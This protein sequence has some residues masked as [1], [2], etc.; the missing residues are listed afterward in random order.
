MTKTQTQPWCEAHL[1]VKLVKTPHG[2]TTCGSWDGEKVQALWRMHVSKSKWP[3]P[4][5]YWL[6]LF[7]LLLIWLFFASSH[8]RCFICPSCRKFDFETSFDDYHYC[9]RWLFVI[10]DLFL[11]LFLIFLLLLL[12]V[13][14]IYLD[15]A[16]LNGCCLVAS[17]SVHAT[18]VTG[19]VR[20]DE[21]TTIGGG[22]WEKWRVH[23][24]DGQGQ[25]FGE[26]KFLRMQGE[27]CPV[28]I[29]DRLRVLSMKIKHA[30]TMNNI[31]HRW[32]MKIN[33]YKWA[34]FHS[35]LF[36]HKAPYISVAPIL[37]E[38]RESIDRKAGWSFFHSKK[39]VLKQRDLGN[40][41]PGY[42]IRIL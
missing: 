19:A 35:K 2:R 16:L 6:F 41:W 22:P 17:W 15:Q 11:F 25:V 4:S 37:Q 38:L 33:I 9:T 29:G 13:Y 31:F 26:E 40:Q 1:E 5:F 10:F 8:L 32:I 23:C 12:F 14:V 7:C 24:E 34:I 28:A 21:L 42:M 20:D 36:N 27:W 3:Q 18:C 30:E 39:T